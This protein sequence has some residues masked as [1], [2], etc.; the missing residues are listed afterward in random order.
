MEVRFI[1]TTFRDGSQSLWAS[2]IRPGMMEAVAQ[3]MARAGFDVIEVPGGNYIKK[4]VRDLKEDPWQMARML[5]RKMPKAVKSSMAGSYI[6]ALDPLTPRSMIEFYYAHLVGIGYLNRVQV[7]SN[8]FDQTKRAFPWILPV[9]RSLGLKVVL[10]LSYAISPRHS[11]EY[12]AQKTREVVAFK[13]DA[14]YLKDQG[15]LLTVDRARTLLPVLVKNANGVPVELHS[16][17]TTGLAPLVYLEALKL[18]I[19]RLHTAVP[20]LANGSGQP[21]IFNVASNARLM[22]YTPQIDLEVLRPVSERMTEMARQ[23]KLPIGAPLEYDYAQYVHQVPGGVISNL[24]H[25]LGELGILDRLDEVFEEIVQVLKDFGYPI[26]ITP[27][28][29]FVCTQA[30]INVATGERY[31]HVIDDM[32]LF[33][34]GAYG[35]DSGY[36]WMDQNLRDRL[37]GLPRAKELVA[38]ERPDVPL[39]TIRKTL[40]GPGVSD[41]EFLLR[42]IMKGEDEIRAM[43][44]TPPRQYHH[45]AGSLVTLLEELCKHRRVRFVRVERGSDSLVVRNRAPA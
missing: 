29:Q 30:A 38:R 23:E 20:P 40:G 4:C 34:K 14:I 22:G 39:E 18:G 2:G 43:R 35:E 12:Y 28:S 21:S 31:K 26:M 36:P 10:A 8:T 41:D 1:D 7:T 33:A 13:P 42:Y 17:C 15:G 19:G 5:A 24:K 32:I 25:Q 6:F 9:F 45:G 44:A 16:H 3:D 11:D 27:Y 37:I